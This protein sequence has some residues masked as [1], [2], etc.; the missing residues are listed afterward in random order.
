MTR[1]RDHGSAIS[2]AVFCV[3]MRMW[4]QCARLSDPEFELTDTALLFSL[5]LSGS[6]GAVQRS[7]NSSSTEIAL[8]AGRLCLSAFSA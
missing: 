6:S 3:S 2:E 1:F 5:P 4:L 7:S 8:Q